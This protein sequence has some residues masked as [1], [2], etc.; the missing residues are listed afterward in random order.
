MPEKPPFLYTGVDFFGP[1][2]VHQGRSCVKKYGCII[3]CMISRSVHLEVLLTLTIDSF[4]NAFEGSSPSKAR[5]TPYLMT[6]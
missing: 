6:T 1:V 2:A 5:Y 4:L 3:T